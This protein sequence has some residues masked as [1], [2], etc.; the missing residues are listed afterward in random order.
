MCY[1]ILRVTNIFG[2]KMFS[3]SFS[4]FGAKVLDLHGAQKT[5]C[6]DLNPSPSITVV[7][8]GNPSAT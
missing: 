6:M 8:P 3:T 7:I 1:I 5:T 4:I 2:Q